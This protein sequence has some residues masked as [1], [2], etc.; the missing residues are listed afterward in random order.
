MRALHS[1]DYTL[2]AL[3]KHPH[4]RC[5]RNSPDAGRPHAQSCTSGKHEREGHAR[6]RAGS[7]ESRL[8]TLLEQQARHTAVTPCHLAGTVVPKMEPTCPLT[9]TFHA[10]RSTLWSSLS[11]RYT[12]APRGHYVAAAR[13]ATHRGGKAYRQTSDQD[14]GGGARSGNRGDPPII[15]PTGRGR[16]RAD[17]RCAG[18]GRGLF[19][20]FR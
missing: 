8:D 10:T 17:R 19:W 16:G 14:S 15:R 20:P 1:T 11:S 13:R 5:P 3:A 9:T 6:L 18:R 7:T 12:A 4:S 2:R